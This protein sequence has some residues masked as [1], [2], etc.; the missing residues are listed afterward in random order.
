MSLAGVA[1]PTI[2][3]MLGHKDVTEDRPYLSYNREQVS[4]VAMDF[5]DVPIRNGIYHSLLYG[6]L[7][8]GGDPE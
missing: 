4:F 3:Q 5:S 6:S 8:K 2:S 7:R 1:L